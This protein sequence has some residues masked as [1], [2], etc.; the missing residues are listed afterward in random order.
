MTYRFNFTPEA[1]GTVLRMLDPDS[2]PVAVDRWALEAPDA[3]LP[4]VD[5]VGQLEAADKALKGDDLVIL[6]HRAVAA[7]SP[8]E[9]ASL[10]L[11]KLADVLARLAG[12]GLMTQ[13]TFQ[14]AL[15]WATP[16][17]KPILGLERVGAFLRGKNAASRLPE[18]L[19]DIAQ[20]VDAVNAAE[21]DGKFPAIA[22]LRDLLPA[23][24]D[25]GLAQASGLLG[26]MTIA[27][28][29]AFSLDLKGQGNAAVLVPILHRARDEEDTLL[30][31]PEQQALF[32]EKHFNGFSDARAVYT[33]GRNWYVVLQPPLRRALSEVRQVNSGP[34]AL[35]R[36]FLANPRAFLREALGDDTDEVVLNS[37]FRETQAYADRVVG[38]GL[39]TP[40]VVPWIKLAP[41][42]WFGEGDAPSRTS[43]AGQS[44]PVA[45]IELG[46]RRI[47][48]DAEQTA[49]LRSDIEG[50][51]TAGRGTVAC[52]VGEETLTVPATIATLAALD[53]LDH[54]RASIATEPLPNAEGEAPR[55]LLI[56]PNE[57]ALDIE[58]LVQSARPAPAYGAPKS[59][60]TPLKAHQAEGLR[61]LQRA[62]AEGLPGVLLADDMGLGKTLQGLA[63][64]AWL[65]D[66][67]RAGMIA[68][69]PLLIVAPTG[70]LQNWRKEHDLHLVAP[71]LGACTEAFGRGLK[72]L[73]T[74]SADGAP[75]LDVNRLAAADWVLTTYETLRDHH[76]DFGRVRFA[77]LLFDEAQK[78][79]TPG[80]RLTD[81]AKAM[82]AEIQV[83]LTG[84]PV[85]NRLADLWCIVDTVQPGWLGDLKSFSAEYERDFDE[86]RLRTLKGQLER[87][88]G[89]RPPL[90]LRRMKQDHLPDLPLAEERLLPRPMPPV[91]QEA[92][93]AA[94]EA[95]RAADEP[96]AVLK[97]LQA[98]RAV[99]LH[100]CPSEPAGDG[101]FIAA[102]ARL[103]AAIETLDA[104][105]SAGERA[106]V[107][108]GD[109]DLQA[110][111]AG[112]LQ[113]RYG[114]ATP[115][116][117]INGSV[118]G[119][120]RQAYVDR[121]QAASGGFDVMILSPQAGG[122]GLTLTRANHV[123]H[124]SR[125]WNPAVEDQCTGRVHRIGQVRPVLVHIPLAVRADGRPS[126]DQNLAALLERKRKLMHD[127]LMPPDATKD[128][129]RE[130]LFR[131]TVGAGA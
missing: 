54:A 83:A 73:K 48:L 35:R 90:M 108:L 94:I 119:P 28:A 78:I 81:A 15:E 59:L 115:P 16:L 6:D 123:I 127:T 2:R 111:L 31:P 33:L 74:T 4:G 3:L 104:V 117:I 30:L 19:F 42:D 86:T 1:S 103:Q 131:D 58:S 36:A 17:G 40:R 99:S 82:K 26:E 112:I 107:F 5:L 63:F 124:L 61:W 52:S 76:L 14:V 101:A 118:A 128:T 18:V 10:G 100:P 66:G 87:S 106:L 9:A 92:Y 69:A 105:A 24:A 27:V 110:R 114:L 50:A 53:A 85:E 60:A 67:M 45:G 11:P 97:A 75:A 23:G 93:D 49:A 22:A 8:A 43:R 51:I 109:L 37:V 126:F 65:R 116:L 56:K 89:G 34:P 7:L 13:P 95:A 57:D 102:S 62:W 71:G 21:R 70:L 41:T 44:E 25:A 77:A 32:G 96:G 113:R 39:W 121:F 98:L 47:A 68:P 125:W 38:L 55:V 129:D 72:A 12:R 29:D 130:I 46:G 84:T 64:L 79:K 80:I 88:L 20:A 122:V 120:K 91:Q